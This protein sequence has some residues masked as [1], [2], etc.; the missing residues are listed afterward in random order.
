VASVK[1]K[2]PARIDSSL[3]YSP[4]TAHE[5]LTRGAPAQVYFSQGIMALTLEE[6]NPGRPHIAG[7]S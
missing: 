7:H 3:T 1:A 5:N 2:R 4:F 6:T